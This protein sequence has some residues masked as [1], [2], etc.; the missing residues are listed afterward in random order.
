MFENIS[1]ISQIKYLIEKMIDLNI[2]IIYNLNCK[3]STKLKRVSTT[4]NKIFLFCSIKYAKVQ[5]ILN[6][7]IVN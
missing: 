2:I 4:V 6:F 3:I 1:F 5:I 7:F